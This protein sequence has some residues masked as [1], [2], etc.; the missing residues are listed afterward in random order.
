MILNTFTNSSTFRSTLQN[1][2]MGFSFNIWFFTI[3]FGA[4]T[5]FDDLGSHIIFDFKKGYYEPFDQA[6]RIVGIAI[7]MVLFGGILVGI[8]GMY[9]GSINE[10][11]ISWGI[12][13]GCLAVSLFLR[14]Q[15]YRFGS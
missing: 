9:G 2:G 10:A 6:I 13:L 1:S 8:Y 15:R 5:F 14:V 11:I 7:G 3:I 4:V 12:T